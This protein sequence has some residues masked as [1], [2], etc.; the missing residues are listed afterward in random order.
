MAV[1]VLDLVSELVA[2]TRCAAC[3]DHVPRRALFCASCGVSVIRAP[4]SGDVRAVFEYG[5]AIASAIMRFKYAGR[6]DLALRLA[7][8]MAELAAQSP[9][10]AAAE[11]VVP[12]PLHP[13]RVIERGFD[14]ASLLAKP[15]ARRLGVPWGVGALERIVATPKQATLDRAAR[16]ANVAGAFVVARGDAIAGRRVLLVDDVRTTGATLAA[17]TRVLLEKGAK[18]VRTLVMARRGAS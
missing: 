3:D 5:G 16:I 18:V 7:E 2:P 12:V 6:S 10:L 17:C 14:Q 11:I 1:F 4:A 15:I 9:W 8:P 13:R